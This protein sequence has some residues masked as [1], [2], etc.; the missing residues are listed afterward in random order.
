MATYF[1]HVKTFSRGKGSSATKAAAYRAG[2]RIRDENSGAVHDY[3]DRSDVA[4][5]EIVLPVKF[6]GAVD[7]EWALHRSVLWNAVQQ[8]GRFW[9]SRLARE[10]LV[11]VP[12]ELT[13]AQRTSLVRGFSQELADRYGSAV[14]FAVHRP[15]AHADQRH[16]HAHLLMTTRQVGPDGI[17]ARTTLD[18][19]GTERHARGLGPSK[20]DLLWI[21][22]RWAQVTNEALREAGIAARIDH[23]SYRA[24]GIDREPKPMF[25]QSIIYA[26]RSTGRGTPAGDD[27]RARYRERVEARAKGGEEL[28]RVIQRQKAEGRQHAIEWT[29][30]HPAPKKIPQGALTRKQLNEAIRAR[31]KLHAEEINRKVRERR[32]ANAD[33]ENRKQR[34]Y[35]RKH[36]PDSKAARRS[37][38][39]EQRSVQAK[40]QIEPS[41][42]QHAPPPRSSPPISAEESLKKWLA[43]REQHK[44]L[45]ADDSLKKWRAYREQHKELPADDSLKAWLAYRERTIQAASPQAMTKEESRDTGAL[46]A[47]PRDDDPPKK[48]SQRG[49]KHGAGL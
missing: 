3:T 22:E 20:N 43:Y 48:N 21:R 13:P 28:A 46:P 30:R 10:V 17:G 9:N 15:R 24:Q 39:E 41:A 2:E 34:E 38:M 35:Y 37:L 49:R 6:A 1:L 19:S 16:H 14:D 45:P 7:M 29:Q 23:R 5:A 32:R 44:E 12:P 42:Q 18:L 40:S 31:R 47:A 4:H 27:I 8:S 33:E 26:E 25:P 11:H 36:H